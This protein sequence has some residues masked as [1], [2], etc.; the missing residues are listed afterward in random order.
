MLQFFPTAEG[1]YDSVK[2]QYVFNY[3]DHLGNVRLSYSDTNKN[4][5]AEKTEI[6]EENN[7]YPFGLKQGNIASKSS[8]KY[9]YNGKELQDELGLNVYDYGARNY[10]PAVGRWFNYDPL[11]EKSRRFSPY[12]Y[13]LDN[14]IY[15]IDPDG[16]EA[17]GNGN[18]PK[19]LSTEYDG[20]EK[21]EIYGTNNSGGYSGAVLNGIYFL[22]SNYLGI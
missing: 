17:L 4:G 16:M 21:I 2:Q 20:S 12:T 8:Y 10:D 3:V 11:A 5:I 15:F 14:P 7:Y 22:D 19:L 6:L 1:Y 13:A 9:K 18:P